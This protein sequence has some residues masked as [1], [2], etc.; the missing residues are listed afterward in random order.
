M[1]RMKKDDLIPFKIVA[2]EVG[3]SR[4]SLWRARR[5]N[6]P[7]FP[8]PIVIRRLVYWR[9]QDLERLDE[10]LLRYSGRV[11][12]ERQREARRKVERLQKRSKP[13]AKRVRAV[14]QAKP[15]QPDLFDRRT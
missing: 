8:A 15:P 1:S 2:E 4:T 5:S 14:R 10:A 3:M 13:A 7:G 6:I 9:R 12:F 11:N